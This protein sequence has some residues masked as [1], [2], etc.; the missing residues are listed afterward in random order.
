M[1]LTINI[2]DTLRRSVEAASGG[3]N[4]VLYTAKGQPSY[5]RVVP[6]RTLESFTGQNLGTGTHPAFIVNSV[7][8]ANLFLGLYQG[9]V[10]NGELLSL[11]GVDPAHSATHDAFVAYARAAGAGWHCMSNPEWALLGHLCYEQGFQPGG[12]NNYGQ[13]ESTG[14][15]GVRADTGLP[16]IGGSGAGVERTLT[17]SGPT[18]WRHDNTAFGIAD[19]NGNIWEWSPGFRINAGEINI[20]AN[21]DSALT[22]TDLAAGSAA[23]RAIDGATGALV[24]PGTAGTVKYAAAASGTADFTLYC[25]SGAA[26]SGMANST[27][28]NP[29]GATALALIKAHGGFPVAATGLGGDGFWVDV[30]SERVPFRGGNRN[31]GAPYGV[32]A[33]AGNNARSNVSATLG[34]RPAFVA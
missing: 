8:K 9:C 16:A 30:T 25:A 27:G 15:Y 12:N 26:F 32:F 31:G 2:P 13:H 19:L 29:V 7:A 28:A 4:T 33:L 24:A 6:L 10:K 18:S 17:G 21:N 3:R 20:V 5:M 22:A 1:A 14:Q 34:A 23:W 11:P